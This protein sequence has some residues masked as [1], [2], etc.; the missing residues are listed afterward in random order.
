MSKPE[1]PRASERQRPARGANRDAVPNRL[2]KIG[3]AA[4][5]LEVEAYVLRFWETQFP[6]LRPNNSASKHR[7]YSAEDMER[8][9]L[10]KRLLYEEGFTIEG[11]RKRIKELQAGGGQH[12]PSGASAAHPKTAQVPAPAGAWRQA[13]IDIRRDLESLYRMLKD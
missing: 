4:R 10:I 3:E 6:G 11:A 2:L 1:E 13:L 12:L 5:L 8:L 9:R 7:L